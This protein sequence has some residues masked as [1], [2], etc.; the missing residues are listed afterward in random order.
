MQSKIAAILAR[1]TEEERHELF[2]RLRKQFRIH[3]LED[4]VGADAETILEA[5][6]RA[7]P[8]TLRMMRGVI[9]EAAFEVHVINPLPSWK[10]F[11]PAGAMRPSFVRT[12]ARPSRK[13]ARSSGVGGG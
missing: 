13:S 8:L 6:S 5:I 12:R 7:G 4:R 1:C 2:V 3:P 10:A 11:S 9:A